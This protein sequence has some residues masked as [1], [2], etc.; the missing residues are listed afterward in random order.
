M[1][2]KESFIKGTLILAAAALIAR[3][4]GIAQKVPLEHMLGHAGNISFATASNVYLT[5]LTVAT[6]GIPSTISKMVSERYALNKEEEAQRV[7]RAA[8]LFG[9]A[10]GAVITVLLYA[11]A[12][13]YAALNRVPE[14]VS[15]IRALAPALLMFPTIAM[16][17]G[18]FQGRNMMA[19]GG[20]SQ[21]VEQ[22]VRVVAA[23]GI[24][25]AL[26]QWGYSDQWVA[27]G[28]SFGGVLGGIA[29]L[30]VMIYYA[31]K[32]KKA[33]RQSRRTVARHS[34]PV[35]LR[36]IYA[37]IFKISVPLIFTA[38][39]VQ[40]VYTVDGTIGIRLLE[41]WH[42][43]EQAMQAIDI[44]S[45]RA[46]AVAGIPPILAIALSTSLLPVISAAFARGDQE[47][48][49]RQVTLA[50]RISIFTGMPIVLALSVAA[51]SV[52]GLLFSTQ[53]GAAIVGMLTAGTI[54]QITM[55]VTNSIL[56]GVSKPNAAMVHVII[57]IAGKLAFS[58][59]LAPW[60]GIYG[61][62]AATTLCFVIITLLNI[63]TLKKIVPFQILGNRWAGFAATVAVL[64][65]VGGG[66]EWAGNLLVHLLP[67]RV[68]FFLSSGLVGLAVLLLYPALLVALRIVTAEELNNYPA[69]LRKA[70]KPFMRLQRSKSA[71]R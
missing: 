30:L 13:A 23:L 57:G 65:A 15:A 55:M 54:F 43:Y 14:S 38:I 51:Y 34:P 44:L 35:P 21:I 40:A 61:I 29:A 37:D 24:A 58:F 52:N 16:M 45:M 22:I 59:I 36:T 46:Q 4:L 48:L 10:T 28:A 9:F 7:Y 32:L 42:G 12:P 2:K 50:M 1:S 41:P 33:D 49:N 60:L 11:F 6:A 5:L 47:H 8:L 63:R 69:P 71:M 25:F 18:Y 39:T 68:A 27:A 17:R 56:L 53:D 64:A 67:D 62:I 19:P 70:L 66:V 3:V 20:V 31:R 26:L